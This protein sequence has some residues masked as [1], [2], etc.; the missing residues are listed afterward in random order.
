MGP[1][2]LTSVTSRRKAPLLRSPSLFGLEPL[3]PR[4]VSLRRSSLH[5]RPFSSFSLVASPSRHVYSS[6]SSLAV[7]RFHARRFPPPRRRLSRPSRSPS[8][9]RAHRPSPSGSALLPPPAPASSS[10]ANRPLPPS[11][12]PGFYL[13]LASTRSLSGNERRNTLATFNRPALSS[14]YTYLADSASRPRS[15]PTLSS[16]SPS[17]PFVPPPPASPRRNAVRRRCR[18]VPTSCFLLLIFTTNI[19]YKYL[20]AL[21]LVFR[22]FCRARRACLFP[23][24]F[25]V[26]VEINCTLQIPRGLATFRSAWPSFL[27]TD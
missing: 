1:A 24:F 26:F 21:S 22:A 20:R 18:R 12:S 13:S 4:T 27:L 25:S 9:P 7:S 8:L 3:K 23:F 15:S 11:L 17:S 16:S 14:A 2:P 6:S 10:L 5:Y 19:V